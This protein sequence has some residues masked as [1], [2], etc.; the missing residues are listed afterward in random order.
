[1][2]GIV[3]AGRFALYYLDNDFYLNYLFPSAEL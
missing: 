1:M 2:Y 3:Y